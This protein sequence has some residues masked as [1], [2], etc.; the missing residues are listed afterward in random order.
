MKIEDTG[1]VPGTGH[2]PSNVESR[3]GKEAGSPLESPE[4]ACQHS[5]FSPVRGFIGIDVYTFVLVMF[6]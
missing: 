4:G 6:H 3:K 5:D 1:V 2:K